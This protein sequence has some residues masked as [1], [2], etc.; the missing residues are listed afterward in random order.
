MIQTIVLDIGQ[1]L[2][3]F[4]WKDYLEDCGYDE[5][6][7]LKVSR[8]TVLSKLWEEVDRGALSNE[9]ILKLCCALEPSVSTEITTLFEN[10]KDCVREYEYSA[11]FVKQLKEN[12]YKVYL[13]SNYGKVGFLYAKENFKFF[14]YIDGG[15]I[16]YEV[17]HIKPEP[18]IYNILINKYN[19][20][21]QEAVFLDDNPAN[22]EA[23]KAFGFHTIL[24]EDFPK[25]LEELK[26]LGVK[27]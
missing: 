18:E 23:A 10:I 25:A 13:L 4:R 11:P 7:K 22:L 15:V 12:G 8:A 21:P 19:F 27:L 14:Q 1:V 17:K 2:A 5:E 6:T 16:S 26:S 3:S 24:V 9:E 20:N